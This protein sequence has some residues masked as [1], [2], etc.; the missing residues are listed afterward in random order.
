MESGGGPQLDQSPQLWPQVLAYYIRHKLQTDEVWRSLRV[1]LSAAD[2]P[3]EGELPHRGAAAAAGWVRNGTEPV[4]Q[5]VRF[6]SPV[7]P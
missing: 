2:A 3:G 1:I 7:G 6:A 5:L 4:R